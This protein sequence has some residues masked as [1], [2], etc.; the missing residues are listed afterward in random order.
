M[1]E[2]IKRPIVDWQPIATAPLDDTDVLVA[3]EHTGR[4]GFFGPVFASF[5]TYHPNAQ[6]KPAWR[7]VDGSKLDNPTHWC[8]LPMLPGE[9]REG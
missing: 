5:R 3:W 2:N 7:G 9:P 4:R 8:P 6:G 1:A